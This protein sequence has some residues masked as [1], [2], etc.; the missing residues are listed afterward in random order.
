MERAAS[1]RLPS[2]ARMNVMR[3]SSLPYDAGFTLSH[4]PVSALSKTLARRRQFLQKRWSTLLEEE[5]LGLREHPSPRHPGTPR[6]PRLTN[7]ST[8]RST[9]ETTLEDVDEEEEDAAKSS[10]RSVRRQQSAER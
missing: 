3:T 10:N 4:P 8:E 5:L 9:M 6:S 1:E 7:N 2:A